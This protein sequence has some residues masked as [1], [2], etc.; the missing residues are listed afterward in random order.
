MLVYVWKCVCGVVCVCG[1]FVFGMIDILALRWFSRQVGDESSDGTDVCD[2]PKDDGQDGEPQSLA[3]SG[4]RPL[5]VPLGRRLVSLRK[6]PQSRLLGQTKGGGKKRRAGQMSVHQSLSSS[7]L[8]LSLSN[9]ITPFTRLTYEGFHL[10]VTP[11][12]SPSFII[13]FL[14]PSLHSQPIFHGDRY[15]R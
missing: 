2:D 6:E 8:S 4:T 7:P 1:L 12:S 14:L 11:T 9:H 13:L 5:E 15:F 10:G 3:R